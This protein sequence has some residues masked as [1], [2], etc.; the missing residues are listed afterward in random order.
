MTKRPKIKKETN[1]VNPLWRIKSRFRQE[2]IYS[3]KKIPN[4]I[5]NLLTIFMRTKSLV[6]NLNF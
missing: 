2:A 1:W 6:K 5:V 3:N 4:I